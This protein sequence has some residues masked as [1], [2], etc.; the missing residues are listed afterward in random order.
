MPLHHSKCAMERNSLTELPYVISAKQLMYCSVAITKI[1][2]N[3]RII[4][5]VCVS[6]LKSHYGDK[7]EI[8]LEIY[9]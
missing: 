5:Y 7:L 2:D 1:I 8:C 3:D 4:P 9:I 6:G